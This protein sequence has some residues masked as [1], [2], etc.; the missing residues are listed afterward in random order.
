DAD[1]LEVRV[2][3]VGERAQARDRVV[4]TAVVHDDDRDQRLRRG[5]LTH[6]RSFPSAA[7]AY[8]EAQRCQT[9]AR[10][11]TPRRV[12]AL[13]V[14]Y[15]H[16]SRRPTEASTPSRSRTAKWGASG[17]LL[18][19]GR[20][21]VRAAN[22]ASSRS[23]TGA[24]AQRSSVSRRLRSFQRWND[25]EPGRELAPCRWRTSTA[26]TATSQPARRSRHDVSVSS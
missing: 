7:S 2:V 13:R 5:L 22:R 10:P 11:T 15:T 26:A 24:G 8:P 1:D 23:A 18:R 19:S 6:G 17:R 9:T 14:R 4:G 12:T 3:V 25:A 20:S 21:A 16:G